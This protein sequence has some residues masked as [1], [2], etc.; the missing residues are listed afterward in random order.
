MKWPVLATWQAFWGQQVHIKTMPAILPELAAVE[1]PWW[2][3]MLGPLPQ[4]LSTAEMYMPRTSVVLVYLI[5]HTESWDCCSC[6][7]LINCLACAFLDTHHVQSLGEVVQTPTTI[8][9]YLWPPFE[10]LHEHCYVEQ[11]C[12]REW[13]VKATNFVTFKRPWLVW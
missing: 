7:H 5:M 11:A 8:C 4:Q 9:P 13:S 12:C 6:H 2:F 3:H 1:M 10:P